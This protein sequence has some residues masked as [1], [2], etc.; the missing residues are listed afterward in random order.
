MS[1]KVV[2]VCSGISAASVAW[3]PLGFEFVAFAE[4]DPFACHVLSHRCG[5]TAPRRL[6]DG[7]DPKAFKAISG[8]SVINFGDLTQI[9]DDDLR[10]LG[11]VDILEG[12]TPCQG[13]SVAGLRGGLMDP[14]GALTLAFVQ[15]AHRMRKLNRLR[16]VVWENVHGIFGDK[17]KTPSAISWQRWQEN[18]EVRWSRQGQD[19]QIQ[20]TLLDLPEKSVGE[21]SIPNFGV[22][23]SAANESSLSH[24]LE[25]ADRVPEKYWASADH[26]RGVLARGRKRKALT[27]NTAIPPLLEAALNEVLERSRT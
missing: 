27:G 21:S 26:A 22:S 9:S 25:P 19:G 15:L 1:L 6:P 5:A 12:G 24:V 7:M 4:V 2:S 16:Y 13:F 18:S 3:K 23:P 14:R 10:A 17:G 20:V 11:T 8:G